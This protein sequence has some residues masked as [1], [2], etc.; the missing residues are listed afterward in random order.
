M[1][2]VRKVA[3]GILVDVVGTAGV[4]VAGRVVGADVLVVTGVVRLVVVI[5]VVG[6]DLVSASFD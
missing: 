2:M 4:I 3:A 6:G 5:F 1:S